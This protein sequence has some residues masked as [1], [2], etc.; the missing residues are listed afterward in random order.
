MTTQN[1][2]LQDYVEQLFSAECIAIDDSWLSEVRKIRQGWVDVPVVIR[3]L[4]RLFGVACPTPVSIVECLTTSDIV[5]ASEDGLKIRRKHPLRRISF[6]DTQSRSGKINA[7]V[8]SHVFLVLRGT[9]EP[10]LLERIYPPS[11]SCSI[12]RKP[13]FKSFQRSNT[14]I[15]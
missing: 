12:C 8:M 10:Y 4:I 9:S 13:A 1:S 3:H 2:K 14:I 6:P 11:P 15:I 5:T 7:A